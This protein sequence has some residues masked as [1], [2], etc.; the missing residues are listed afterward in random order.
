MRTKHKVVS[1]LG[2]ES[3]FKNNSPKPHFP[4]KQ[5]MS[6]GS[7]NSAYFT[8]SMVPRDVEM[9]VVTEHPRGAQKRVYVK[10]WYPDKPG[11]NDATQTTDMTEIATFLEKS[12]ETHKPPVIYCSTSPRRFNEWLSKLE[13]NNITIPDNAIFVFPQTPAGEGLMHVYE[14]GFTCLV[15]DFFPGIGKAL[16]DASGREVEIKMGCK[17]FTDA[18]VL[19]KKGAFSSRELQNLETLTKWVSGNHQVHLQRSYGENCMMPINPKLHLCGIIA[20]MAQGISG[21]DTHDAVSYV[22]NFTKAYRSPP[23]DSTPELATKC[24]YRDMPDEAPDMLMHEL[25]K[26]IETLRKTIFKR[27]EDQNIERRLGEKYEKC[28]QFA[29][30]KKPSEEAKFSTVIHNIPYYQ[31]PE[32]KFPCDQKGNVNLEHR[33]FTEELPTLL[34]LYKLGE[35]LKINMPLAKAIIRAIQKIMGKEYLHEDGSIGQDAPKRFLLAK[36]SLD[37]WSIITPEKA[38]E[39]VL[40]RIA[41]KL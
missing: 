8:A 37:W 19:R 4:F 23:K 32:I 14:K 2:S 1:L 27:S 31:N 33:F 25:S 21:L 17:E 10:N 30:T 29:T 16:I 38:P 40:P 9:M 15:F 35:S 34:M 41:S 7:G 26:E 18:A 20:Y 28:Y 39:T 36:N 3:A 5:I 24:F 12:R 22:E 11:V 13:A 6:I